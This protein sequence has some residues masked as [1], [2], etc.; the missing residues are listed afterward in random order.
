VIALNGN[1]AP[2]GD[3]FKYPPRVWSATDQ[4]PDKYD[5]IVPL[6]SNSAQKLIEFV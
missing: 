4:V 2:F 6:G 3:N 5:S 1:G